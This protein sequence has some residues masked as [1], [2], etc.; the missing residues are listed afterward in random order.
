MAALESASEWETSSLR[1]KHEKNDTIRK[2][3]GQLPF[4]SVCCSSRQPFPS[5]SPPRRLPKWR[6]LRQK[7]ARGEKIFPSKE[8]FL[9]TGESKKV[10]SRLPAE[11]S[12]EGFGTALAVHGG[13]ND[14]PGVASAFTAGEKA[15]EAHMFQSFVVA[16][17]TNGRRSARFGGDEDRLVGEETSTAAAEGL[18]AL[19]QTLGDEARHPEMQ[20]RGDETRVVARFR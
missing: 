7:N 14:A 20:G 1:M 3:P 15:G 13:R 9:A 10:V 5:S 6:T 2:E 11:G 19:L 17:H 4:C 8:C 16:H 12:R 18:E